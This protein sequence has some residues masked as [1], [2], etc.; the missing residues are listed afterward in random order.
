MARRGESRERMLRAAARLFQRQGYGATGLNQVVEEGSAPK[1]SLYFHFPGGKEQLAAEAVSM[2]GAE[3]G[4]AMAATAARAEDVG[5][6]I[7]AVAELFA[8]ELERSD[9]RAGCPVATVALDAAADSEPIRAACDGTYSSW[10]AGMAEL[11]RRHRVEDAEAVAVLVVSA[12]Q[13]AL[14]LA[15][16][17]RDAT[18]VRS[19]ARQVADLALAAKGAR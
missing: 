3:L 7:M 1:G 14:L 16:V 13:G 17:R 8:A 11:L 12:I 2:A 10:L 18:V 9:Y 6:A 19:T 4:T 15:R 5:E